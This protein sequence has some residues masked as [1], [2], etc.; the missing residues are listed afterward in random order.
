MEPISHFHTVFLSL[1]SNLGDKFGN[2]SMAC[3]KLS[4][5]AGVL[6]D[7]SPVYRTESWGF[8][9]PGFLNI[10][11]MLKTPFSPDKLWQII[12]EIERESGGRNPGP[13]Y[14]SRYLDIDILYYDDRIVHTGELEI[15]HP[16]IPLRKFVLVPLYDIA[17]AWVHPVLKKTTGEML[18]A[19]G[20]GARVETYGE[21]IPFERS[22]HSG[23]QY[24]AIEGNIG[25]GKTTLTHLLAS[26]YNA[27]TVLERFADN[28]FLP[29]FYQDNERYA[30]PL[31][32]SFLADRYQQLSDDLSQFDLFKTFI[33]SDYYIFKS[34]IFAGVTLP[35]DEYTLYR[36]IFNIMYKEIIKPDLYIYLYQN[37]DRLLE[38]IKKRGRE[39]EQQITA[40]YLKQIHDAYFRFIHSQQDLN[41]LVIDVS[42]LDFVARPEDY[43]HIIQTI[44]NHNPK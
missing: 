32:M 16:K 35:H 26:D 38:N 7:V 13:G 42:G 15:P 27:K 23:Y 11:V 29:K 1:G 36:K 9:A 39:Y 10:A 44:K 18:E 43:W 22:L 21:S 5:R 25:A 40:S 4:A 17:P 3:G 33:I 28:P 41:T 6:W 24:I 2:L 14:Q 37:T 34:L 12:R 31:E 20:D 30:L 19:T 8:E